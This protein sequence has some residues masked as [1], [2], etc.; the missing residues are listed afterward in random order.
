MTNPTDEQITAAVLHALKEDEALRSQLGTA[1]DQRNNH[2]LTT[3][4]T[5][6]LE[7]VLGDLARGA[8]QGLKSLV[9]FF[10]NF[11]D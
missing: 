8:W 2:W 11:T 10:L 9:N 4:V 7:G 1:I 6:A 5:R 3:L